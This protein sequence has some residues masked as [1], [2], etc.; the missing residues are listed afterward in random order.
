MEGGNVNPLNI[1]LSDDEVGNT[2]RTLSLKR[3]SCL[4]TIHASRFID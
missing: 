4:V 3:S 1:T 2:K